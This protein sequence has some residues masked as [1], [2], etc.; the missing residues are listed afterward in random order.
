M[1]RRL[2]N[3][4]KATGL[5]MGGTLLLLVVYAVLLTFPGFM[6]AHEVR[7]AN[8][9]AYSDD[10]RPSETTAVLRQVHERIATSTFDAPE[11][12]HRIFLGHDKPVF[13]SLQDLRAE[14]FHAVLGLTPSLTYNA[15]WPP[16]V[17]HVVTFRKP[18]FGHAKLL[19]ESWP[20]AQDMAY[21]L[22]HEVTHSLVLERVGMKGVAALPLWKIEGYP[23]YIAATGIRRANGYSLRASMVRALR[24][25][26]SSMRD[27]SGG[28]RP[29]RYQ[30][31]GQSYVVIE[32]GDYWSTCYYLSRLLVEYQLDV[33][34]L[35]VDEL[36]DPAVT[37]VA[38][39]RDLMAAFESD[40]L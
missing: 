34:R 18:D 2:R 22:T 25:D 31:I 28:L 7:F 6:F 32:T 27:A 4:L 36:L 35:T 1:N 19:S 23:D 39:W 24:A 16:R 11:T 13:R 14:F 29:L 3:V 26:L 8:L 10:D 30:C 15:S 12:T 9:V 37:D 33:R 21:L 5:S 38:T 40:R 17:S 20:T